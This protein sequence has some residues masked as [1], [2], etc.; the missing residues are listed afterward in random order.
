MVFGFLKGLFDRKGESEHL[1]INDVEALVKQGMTRR[2]VIDTLRNRGFSLNVIQRTLEQVE[3]RNQV[4]SG[5]PVSPPKVEVPNVNMELP[6]PPAGLNIPEFPKIPELEEAPVQKPAENVEETI[7]KVGEVEELI[8]AIVEEK[9]SA[10]EERFDELSKIRESV[11]KKVDVFVGEV[12]SI[13]DRVSSLESKQA[14]L[15]EDYKR[16]L[17][18]IKLELD[19]MERVIHKLVPTLSTSI[20][21]L[22][23][24]KKN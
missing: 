8:E 10:V 21:E 13:S 19:A 3:A 12:S 23:E 7:D 9:F 1:P 4:L 6:N 15:V 24:M 16:A 18:D 14:Q 17:N 22:R 2:Q 20:R 11:D 5:A